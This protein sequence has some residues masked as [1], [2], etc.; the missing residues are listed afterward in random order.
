MPEDMR[1]KAGTEG[2][3]DTE[4][5]D[6]K[7]D[8]EAIVQILTAIKEGVK[9]L[10]HIEG[11]HEQVIAQ[12]IGDVDRLKEELIGAFLED[13]H[14]KRHGWYMKFL[15][16]APGPVRTLSRGGFRIVASAIRGISPLVIFATSKHVFKEGALPYLKIGYP[17]VVAA[18]FFLTIIAAIS[19]PRVGTAKW[20]DAVELSGVV[21]E[22]FRNDESI[23]K[24]QKA[25]IDDLL[26]KRKDTGDSSASSEPT[27]VDMRKFLLDHAKEHLPNIHQR[28]LTGSALQAPAI[29]A[30]MW[31]FDA[32]P[33]S[34][35]S[36][37]GDLSRGDFQAALQ[38]LQKGLMG[39]HGEMIHGLRGYAVNL[40]APLQGPV[41]DLIALLKKL[42][43]KK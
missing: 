20:I 15:L 9:D 12:M 31:V 34:F 24:L 26:K 19:I 36:F 30:G 10:P 38:V 18:L 28:I 29:I 3:G 16:D 22:L 39:S 8:A 4:T 33:G 27:T 25:L 14:A 32:Q 37:I 43:A 5:A 41:N 6:D 2:A 23:E 1:P 11:P 35:A 40:V 7:A 17:S 13:S 21:D 42:A